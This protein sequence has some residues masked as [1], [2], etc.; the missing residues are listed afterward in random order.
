MN[1][2]KYEHGCREEEQ[3]KIKAFTWLYRVLNALST[4]IKIEAFAWLYRVL[5]ALSTDIKI[6]AF[7]WLYRVLNAL[8]TDILELGYEMNHILGS[9]LLEVMMSY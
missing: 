7:T 9:S 8:S 1:T 5:N 4:D 3:F 6:E 2:C